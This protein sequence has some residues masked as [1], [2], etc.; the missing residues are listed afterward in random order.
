MDS[1]EIKKA[2]V[3]IAIGILIPIVIYQVHG[4]VSKTQVTLSE[5]TSHVFDTDVDTADIGLMERTLFP[6]INLESP[7]IRERD[8]YGEFVQFVGNSV[9]GLNFL[10]T[11]EFGP[12]TVV[13]LRGTPGSE[14]IR[15][16]FFEINTDNDLVLHLRFRELHDQN[17]IL[18]PITMVW[19]ITINYPFIQLHYD[20]VTLITTFYYN[21][22][23]E[24]NDYS[25]ILS[26]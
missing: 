15:F 25:D 19:N 12:Y 17:L 2:F 6:A 16:G 7:H 13:Y 8:L 3:Y 21:N 22:V 26:E 11:E 18:E 23:F 5:Y 14:T 4:L 9:I 1:T 24:E 20:E 10:S